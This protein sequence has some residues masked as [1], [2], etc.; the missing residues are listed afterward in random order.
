MPDNVRV[1]K[2]RRSVTVT[3]H[4]EYHPIVGGQDG[5]GDPPEVTISVDGKNEI[6]DWMQ[7]CCPLLFRGLHGL[8]CVFGFI[9]DWGPAATLVAPC[10]TSH[11]RVDI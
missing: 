3:P 5:T 4:C 7:V 11:T 8:I 9:Q 2:T 1:T 6:I 10:L